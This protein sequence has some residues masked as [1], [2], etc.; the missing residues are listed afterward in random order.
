MEIR[1]LATLASNIHDNIKREEERFT[2][3]FRMRLMAVVGD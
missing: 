3:A 2:E 1:G